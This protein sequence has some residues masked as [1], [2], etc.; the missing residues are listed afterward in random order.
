MLEGR[1]DF[2][3]HL[4]KAPPDVEVVLVSVEVGWRFDFCE[5][6]AR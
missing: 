4:A 1:S 2:R 5:Q 6:F 3:K